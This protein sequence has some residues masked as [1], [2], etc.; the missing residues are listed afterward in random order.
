MK[1]TKF[2]LFIVISALLLMVSPVKVNSA[3]RQA[4][5]FKETYCAVCKALDD[6]GYITKMEDQGIN[7]IFYD[8]QSDEIIA[9]YN[10]T[11]SDGNYVEVT[12]IDV[13]AA[14]NSTYQR[15]NDGVPALFVGDQYFEDYNEITEA[16]DNDTIFNLSDDP[17]LDVTVEEGKAFGDLSGF[18]G[19]LIVLGA[20]LL[21]GFN[22]CA[23]ALLLLFIG[24]LV[25]AKDKKVL[26]MV[27]FTYIG[28]LFLSY[29]LIGTFFLSVFEKFADQI[30]II[31]LIINWFVLILCFILFSLNFFQA[32]NEKY[33][34]IKNQLPKFVQKYNKKIIKAF[35]G[36]INNE[37][38]KGGLFFVLLVT[39]LL[40]ITLSITELVC[41]GQIY[42]GI[43][44]GIH[45]VG[46][47]Y[48]YF[49]LV[50]YNLM[51]VLPLIVIA[52]LAIR[53]KS[54][55]T[56]SNWI[57]EHLASIKLFTAIFFLVIFVFFLI[58]II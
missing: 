26:M 13:F 56:I 10:Y 32:K 40:G 29:F 2:I 5:I 44:Y 54:V 12:A 31:G 58:R 53:L 45:T 27:S 46:S 8:I 9:E 38:G 28:A 24:L 17:F 41:T 43:L 42:F 25:N 6:D 33:G 7:V 18:V 47:G 51:F 21:D 36:V 39:F 50:F 22:P 4:I 52:V 14:Y 35:T 48:A 19:F 37:D 20:G 34:K 23:I 15:S 16:I 30:S 3:S 11:D 1:K 55:I 49:L 57:R